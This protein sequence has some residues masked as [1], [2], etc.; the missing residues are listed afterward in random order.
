MDVIMR[1]TRVNIV[2]ITSD[3]LQEFETQLKLGFE[4]DDSTSMREIYST[5]LSNIGLLLILKLIDEDEYKNIAEDITEK[6]YL[7]EYSLNTYH[8]NI[9]IVN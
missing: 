3:I 7:Y 9:N 2:S 6:Y 4:Q 1:S 5:S 8:E